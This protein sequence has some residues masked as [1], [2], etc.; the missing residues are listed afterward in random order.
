[1]TYVDHAAGHGAELLEKIWDI[2]AERIVS[3]RQ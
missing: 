3:N 2:G 1:M